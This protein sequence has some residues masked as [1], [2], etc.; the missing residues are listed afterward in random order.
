LL[1]HPAPIA[2][3]QE[4]WVRAA[5]GPISGQLVLLVGFVFHAT[6]ITI[7]VLTF[8]TRRWGG[9][10]RPTSAPEDRLLQLARGGTVDRVMVCQLAQRTG[11][12]PTPK[13]AELFLEIL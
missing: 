13:V 4:F 3:L 9:R 11:R 5:I 2:S 6:W 7:A 12:R 10:G 8:S 1:I